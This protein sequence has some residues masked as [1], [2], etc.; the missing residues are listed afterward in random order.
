MGHESQGRKEAGETMKT[1][2]IGVIVMRNKIGARVGSFEVAR[3]D[4]TGTVYLKIIRGQADVVTIMN[5]EVAMDVA[6]LL[7]AAAKAGDA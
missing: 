5:P 7:T 6:N 3:D 2:S 1:R 4:A